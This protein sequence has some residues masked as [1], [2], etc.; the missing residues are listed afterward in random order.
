MHPIQSGNV[1]G[2]CCSAL[3]V[4]YNE[5]EN[6]SIIVA[7]SPTMTASP[8]HI[9]NFVTHSPVLILLPNTFIILSLS[10]PAAALP[11]K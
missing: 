4:V 10:A 9:A 8:V 1:L 7:D 11:F 3:N 5:G 2:I 6:C